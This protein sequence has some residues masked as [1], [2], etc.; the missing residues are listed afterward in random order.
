MKQ[1]ILIVLGPTA[2]GKS[3]LAIKLAKKFKG[4][5]ISADSRQVYKGLNIGTGKVTKKEMDGIPHY[6]IDIVDPK[7]QFTVSD[8]KKQAET[9]IRYIV[10]RGKLP[11]IVG[12]T[13]FYIDTLT[14]LRSFPE[15]PINIKLRKIL[16]KKTT[17]ELYKSLF[18]KDPRRAKEIDKNN[19]VR[20]IRALEIIDALGEVPPI[21]KLKSKY[22]FVYIGLNISKA[23]LDLKIL[24]RLMSR[25]SN[26]M[27]DEAKKLHKKGLSFKRMEQLGLEYRYLAKY[28]KK[29]I[30][31]KELVDLLYKEIKQY[32]RR[33]NQWFKTNKKIKWF[34]PSE[35]MEIAKYARIA[36]LG[37]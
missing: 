14:G 13:G 16:D 22:E 2:T 26:G 7:K 33:Q 31:K 5:I 21:K 6:L 4:E 9:N 36:E 35:F 20:I 24:K 30:N 17:Q 34:K 23:D 3:A 8:F 12:G 37:P 1:K 18:K 10:Y 29:E 11:I 19:K 32:A 25:L 15:V 27:I 28:L